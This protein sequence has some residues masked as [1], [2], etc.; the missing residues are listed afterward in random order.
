[1]N[2]LKFS[3]LL[4]R[5]S[6]Y[7]FLGLVIVWVLIFSI[8]HLITK[9]HLWGD[10]A[11]SI[12]LARNF[13][14]FG[15][16]DIQTAPGEFS[17]I[18]Y[19]LQS[20]G[21]PVTA[22]L[23]FFF[24]LF[25]PSLVVARLYMLGLMIAALITVFFFGELLFGTKETLLSL[26]L[27]A[28]FASFFD[29]GRTVVGEVP[30][31]L[32]LIT[33]FYFWLF[34]N[35]Y[36]WTG[37]WLGLAIVTK[38]S[39]YALIIPAII[40]VFFLERKDFFKKIWQ[41][42]LGMVPAA[43]GW[44]A[45]VL[46]HPLSKVV[47]LNI[48]NFYKNPYNSISIQ[49]NVLSNLL[50]V[51]HSA[52]LIYFGF[53]FLIIIAASYLIEEKKRKNFYSFTIIYS[54]FAFAYYLRSPGWLRYILIAEL[55]ILFSLPSATFLL[56]NYLKGFISKLKLDSRW[57]SSGFMIV[58]VGIQLFHLFN[59]AKIF[60]SDSEIKASEFI[61]REF[62][63]QTI[64]TINSLAFSVLLKTDKRLQTV[65]MTGLPV[66][67]KNPLFYGSLPEVIVFSP[68][69]IFSKENQTILES[70]YI[71]YSQVS[72]YLIYLLKSKKLLDNI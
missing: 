28:T 39:V 37:F 48:I 45:L 65:E 42:G 17:G 53:L 1:M 52:T 36:Y 30:G 11:K 26:A 55:L 20:T 71:F 32:F 5:Y 10:E 56:F 16:L 57:L 72:N 2:S 25:G 61:N 7:L 12:E 49:K 64:G 38:P 70:H 47:W 3:I 63:N 51:P 15:H 58:L 40:L 34:K 22:P 18:S 24:K 62:P 35:S 67:G 4:K 44:M 6:P 14:K 19:L 21:Y 50:N 41:L 69:V 29:S 33:G 54:I 43:V 13:S 59:G 23:A 31:F 46:N 60:Y 8:P 66:V 68:D 9:P 27:I